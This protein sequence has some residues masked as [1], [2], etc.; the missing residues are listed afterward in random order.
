MKSI[1]KQLDREQL[2]DIKIKLIIPD[3]ILS[4]IKYLCSKIAAVEWSGILF[5][6]VEGTIT[7]PK[8]MLLTIEDI[9]PMHKGTAA[10]TEY[11]FDEK[12][13]EYMMDNEESEKWKIGH[14]HSHNNMGVYF[15]A[16]DWSE[17]EDNAPNHNLYLSL[18]VNNAMN[19]SAKTCFV[20]ESADKK[21]FNFFA[22]N[23][24]GQKYK[25]KTKVM[26]MKGK[27]LVVYDNEVIAP[28]EISVE[29]RFKAKVADII[30]SAERR[31]TTYSLRSTPGLNGHRSWQDRQTNFNKNFPPRTPTRTKT[32]GKTKEEDRKNFTGWEATTENTKKVPG[33]VV[34]KNIKNVDREQDIEEFAK[35]VI[36]T[37][38]DPSPYATIEDV[39][40]Y[41]KQF[42]LSGKALA[43][44]ILDKYVTFYNTFF[45]E[46]PFK[47]EA[48]V[49]IEVTEEV[50]EEYELITTYHIK[51]EYAESMLEPVILG[52]TALVEK[53]KEKED[54]R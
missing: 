35:F 11:N 10:Y 7:D 42:G 6:S 52:L 13:V 3:N 34:T 24:S 1:V 45:H 39:L 4:Q 21:E 48:Q 31:V 25:Y 46:V 15:S 47:D 20:V 17:L 36:N 22:K 43:K 49:F 54:I 51:R 37:G 9:L 2:T 28:T 33:K 8:N 40:D 26:E 19:F 29:E 18:I 41:Y 12:V 30:K 53:I 27:T 5:Y 14:I 44:S 50:I 38:N 32:Y 16:T 23:E